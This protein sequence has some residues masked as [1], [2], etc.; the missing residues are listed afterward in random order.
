[1]ESRKTRTAASAL[2]AVACATALW[3]GGVPSM[4]ASASTT[5]R[6]YGAWQSLG[7]QIIGKPAAASP[8]PGQTTV[9]AVAPDHSVRTRSLSAGGWSS[10]SSLG[11]YTDASPAL[12]SWGPG[13]LDLFVRGADEALWHRWAQN[14]VWSAA[15]D[16]PSSAP[17]AS[18]PAVTSWGA[19]RLDIVAQAADQTLAHMW[20]NGSWSNWESLG[21]RLTSAPAIA[22]P[23]P[24]RLD[25]VAIGGDG[26]VWH[27]SHSTV[28]S[29]WQSLGGKSTF[30][31]AI[32]APS[33]S[34]LEV[35][36]VGT[37][38]AL[39]QQ[40]SQNGWGGW[41]SLGGRAT[42]APALSSSG[43]GAVEMFV[44]GADGGI[45]YAVA[46]SRGL[47][48]DRACG[49]YGWAPPTGKWIVISLECQELSA[50]QDG[51]LVSDT[52]ITTGR[53]ALP[54]ER[55][56]THVIRKN[57]PWLMVSPW[58]PGSPY[59][60]FPSW[61]Q[62]VTWIWPNGTGI[63]DASWEPDSA[64]GPGSTLTQYASHGCV[65]VPLS[66]AQFI[67]DWAD[68]GIPVDVV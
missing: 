14:G 19:N 39:W 64:L 63:H 4:H 68:D 7:I 20:W 17:L 22:S 45:W 15:W 5:S 51:R 29:T 36:A 53:P 57:H 40:A 66:V 25:V 61:V 31:P 2:C 67:Y 60:Y 62:Y 46:A 23:G 18:A 37:D 24:G 12:A 35:A 49:A 50:Y 30:D 8:G 3:A 1:M 9:V 42:S 47:L 28:W 59:Y 13:R 65:H 16:R 10:W 34:T 11:G 58:P 55:G 38:L 32:T 41:S 48:A 27:L 26:A 44:R 6:V 54:T 52:L 21:G 43:F 56:H 33:P